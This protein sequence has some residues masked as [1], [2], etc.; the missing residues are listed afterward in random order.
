MTA[1]AR[2][3]PQRGA[4][5]NEIGARPAGQ[6]PP[7]C[8]GSLSREHPGGEFGD[9]MPFY[10]V[11]AGRGRSSTHIMQ[12]KSPKLAKQQRGIAYDVAIGFYGAP[13]YTLCGLQATRHVNVFI[14]DEASCR[15]CKKRWQLAQAAE[16]AAEQRAAQQR[17]AQQDAARQQAARDLAR[18]QRTTCQAQYEAKTEHLIPALLAGE[19]AKPGRC[20]RCGRKTK[21]HS[22]LGGRWFPDGSDLDTRGGWWWCPGPA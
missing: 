9:D 18:R 14:P 21:H 10:V 8:R 3:Q 13:K 5:A 22:K 11:N 1:L 2:Q 19:T 17:A 6:T 7:C 15:E 4:T 12:S 20:Q 16:A